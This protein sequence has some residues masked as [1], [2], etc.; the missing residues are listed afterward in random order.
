VGN[1]LTVVPISH[2]NIKSNN[3]NPMTTNMFM[4]IIQL[5]KQEFVFSIN[6]RI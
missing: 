1:I 3:H 4:D 5:G 6:G 2:N